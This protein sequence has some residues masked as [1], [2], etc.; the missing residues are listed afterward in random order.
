MGVVLMSYGPILFDPLGLVIFILL[1]FAVGFTLGGFAHART[2]RRIA[3]NPHV[4]RCAACA[5]GGWF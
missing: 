1:A 3:V 4:E 5:R 2:G